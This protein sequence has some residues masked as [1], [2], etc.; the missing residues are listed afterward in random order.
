MERRDHTGCEPPL[1]DV[2]QH[3]PEREHFPLR[4]QSIG[5]AGIA[6]A[7]PANINT[8]PQPAYDETADDRPQQVAERDFDQFHGLKHHPGCPSRSARP[9]SMKR[10]VHGLPGTWMCPAAAGG[11]PPVQKPWFLHEA[12]WAGLEARIQRFIVDS[13]EKLRQSYSAHCRRRVSRWSVRAP[14]ARYRCR[15]QGVQN[16][17][18]RGLSVP[19]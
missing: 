15:P 1:A 13:A 4:P 10:R 14:R 18:D 12:R 19:P 3:N 2:N 8:P 7:E 5:T 16:F 9:R 17:R 11:G 6:A